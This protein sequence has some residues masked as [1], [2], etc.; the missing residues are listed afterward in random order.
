MAH[1]HI[2]SHS[3]K[4]LAFAKDRALS[5]KHH[6]ESIARDKAHA[7]EHLKSMKEHQKAV[8]KLAKGA[9]ARGLGSGRAIGEKKLSKSQQKRYEKLETSS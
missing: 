3:G 8:K 7:K 2:A 1:A 6:K 4:G 5:V 9:P